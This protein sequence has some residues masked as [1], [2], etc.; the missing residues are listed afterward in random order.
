MASIPPLLSQLKRLSQRAA[1]R[2]DSGGANGGVALKWIHEY[3]MA[4]QVPAHRAEG[5]WSSPL[6]PGEPESATWPAQLH[7]AFQKDD[8]PRQPRDRW[9][10]LSRCSRNPRATPLALPPAGSRTRSRREIVAPFDRDPSLFPRERTSQPTAGS[11]EIPRRAI[12]LPG[13]VRSPCNWSDGILK[14]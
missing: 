9:W 10:G 2:V 1:I 3:T 14:Q 11:Q 8:W 13:R 4:R 7:P 6:R 12:K 5:N